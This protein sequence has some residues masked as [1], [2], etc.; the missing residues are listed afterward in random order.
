MRTLL[1]LAFLLGTADHAL[2]Q[3]H[4]RMDLKSAR[5]EATSQSKLMLL[6]FYSDNCAYCQQ[7]EQTVF[8]N[9]QVAQSV[10]SRF[11]PVKIN[12][13]Q[14]PKVVEKFAVK[15]YPTDVVVSV[16]G[17]V[18]VHQVCPREPQSFLAM[19]GGQPNALVAAQAPGG[20]SQSSMPVNSQ[21]TNTSPPAFNMGTQV[22]LAS[23]KAPREPIMEGYC[24]VSLS[25]H[26][27]WVPGNPQFAVIHLGELYWFADA[28]TQAKFLASPNVYAPVMNG[29][30]VV[31]FFDE[32]KI[33]R[34]S[35]EWGTVETNSNRMFFFSSAE[36]LA[37][38]EANYDRYTARA[39]EVSARA[40]ADAN[41]QR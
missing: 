29:I 30:D 21:V 38:Y 32:R 27:A 3:I 24:M 2:A 35:R 23:S 5:D 13:A 26:N 12:G 31:M 33:V 1:L 22:A 39:I 17:D 8:L 19:L 25:D 9:P 40:A 7:V 16:E 36:S 28:S 15:S 20:A 37:R 41:P 6:H 18:L 4:W 10:N 34:G 14:F 11:I